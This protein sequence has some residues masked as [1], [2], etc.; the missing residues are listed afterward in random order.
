[1]QNSV[2]WLHG[3]IFMNSIILVKIVIVPHFP[4]EQY[5]FQDDIALVHRARST[6]DLIHRNGIRTI[7]WS[8][9]SPNLNIIENLWYLLKRKLQAHVFKFTI[10]QP[11]K[12]KH[13]CL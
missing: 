7:S 4:N 12:D 10:M 8:A 5:I 1:M 3:V 2:K 6:Q 9:Q 11:L 13:M